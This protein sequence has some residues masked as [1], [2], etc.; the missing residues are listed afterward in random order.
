MI[1][2]KELQ[3]MIGGFREEKKVWGSQFIMFYSPKLELF[4]ELI[5]KIHSTLSRDQ[6]TSIFKV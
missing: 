2:R 3:A 1:V 5:K 4:K 6:K